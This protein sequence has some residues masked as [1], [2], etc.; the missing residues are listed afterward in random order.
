[1]ISQKSPSIRSQY[2]RH[3]ARRERRSSCKLIIREKSLLIWKQKVIFAGI[4]RKRY[5]RTAYNDNT[6]R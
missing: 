6:K 3:H 1:M 4:I 2:S 5:E